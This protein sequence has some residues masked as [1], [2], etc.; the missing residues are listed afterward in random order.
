MKKPKKRTCDCRRR[1]RG[2][3]KLGTGPCYGYGCWW[4]PAVRERIQGKKAVRRWE[5][6]Y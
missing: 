5:D 3:P 4:R 2:N 6:P 1:K